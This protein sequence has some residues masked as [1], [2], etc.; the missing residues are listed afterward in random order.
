MVCR[1]VHAPGALPIVCHRNT[2]IGLVPVKQKQPV[3]MAKHEVKAEEGEEEG[4]KQATQ[5]SKGAEDEDV[6]LLKFKPDGGV[7]YAGESPLFFLDFNQIKPTYDAS[8]ANADRCVPPLC[9]HPACRSDHHSL[10]P[11]CLLIVPALQQHQVGGYV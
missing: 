10:S 6:Y 4:K 7:A 2:E 11:C 3:F 1:P 5:Q 8:K 9:V